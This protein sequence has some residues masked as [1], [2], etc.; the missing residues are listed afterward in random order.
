MTKCESVTQLSH[1]RLSSFALDGG[2]LRRWFSFR[3]VIGGQEETVARVVLEGAPVAAIAM[4]PRRFD[5]PS[6]S[7]A[8]DISS[9]VLQRGKHLNKKKF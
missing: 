5:A 4:G 9:S 6:A 7:S 2:L 3:C 1:P 8:V